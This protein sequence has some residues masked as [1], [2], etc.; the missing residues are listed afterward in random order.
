MS[1]LGWYQGYV[2]DELR[3]LPLRD[4]LLALRD[5]LLDDLPCDEYEL[6]GAIIAMTRILQDMYDQLRGSASE[7]IG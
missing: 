7:G 4:Q 5:Q 6:A 2:P 3:M 1:G